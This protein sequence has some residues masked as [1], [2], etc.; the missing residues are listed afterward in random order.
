MFRSP[1]FLLHTSLTTTLVIASGGP[2]TTRT[3]VMHK[4]R[5]WNIWRKEPPL[6]IWLGYPRPVSQ[7]LF[8]QWIQPNASTKAVQGTKNVL[9]K[10]H[11]AFP[12]ASALLSLATNTIL[13]LLGH[14]FILKSVERTLCTE[15][16]V[17]PCICDL[18][19]QYILL[20][21]LFEI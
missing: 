19:L 9:S 2:G 8:S 15:T 20:H 16:E 17:C 21:T 1:V 6:K 12:N 18:Y 13:R 7:L 11:W 4:R 14:R 5:S 10:S 3:S